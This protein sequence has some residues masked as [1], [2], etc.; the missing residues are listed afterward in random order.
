METI[1]IGN[2]VVP[3]SG[4]GANGVPIIKATSEEIK[5]P[6][7]RIDVIIKVPCMELNAK[8]EE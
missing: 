3:I 1:K 7:G 8:K 2:K 4:Y 5:H 6:D